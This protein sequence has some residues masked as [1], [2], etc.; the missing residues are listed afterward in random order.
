MRLRLVDPRAGRPHVVL[1]LGCGGQF[2][3]VVPEVDAVID[4]T[5]DPNVSR[6]RRE[7]LQA[8]YALAER[9]VATLAAD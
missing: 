9:I 6:E 4:S 5:S 8:I 1:R 2:V 7:H 3:F